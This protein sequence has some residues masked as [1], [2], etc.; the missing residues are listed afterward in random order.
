MNC[1]HHHQNVQ[2]NRQAPL[3]SA[4]ML[5]QRFQVNGYETSNNTPVFQQPTQPRHA[6]FYS[7]T[8]TT[9]E[10]GK[11]VHKPTAAIAQSP[12]APAALLHTIRASVHQTRGRKFLA[13]EFAIKIREVNSIFSFL[14]D[15]ELI[16]RFEAFLDYRNSILKIPTYV[17]QTLNGL[18]LFKFKRDF[19]YIE[20]FD[21]NYLI[22][23]I[24][25]MIDF[26]YL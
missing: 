14:R 7:A 25:K 1:D 8:L 26:R 19:I 15:L 3:Y 21:F 16:R 9:S 11:D 18:I 20:L 2:Q 13:A 4:G 12:T 23:R 24:I 17:D 22:T 5:L 10:C 6:V